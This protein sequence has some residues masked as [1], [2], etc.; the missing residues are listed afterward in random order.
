[1]GLV[2][3]MWFGSENNKRTGF[4]TQVTYFKD[5]TEIE[6]IDAEGNRMEYFIRVDE[7]KRFGSHLNSIGDCNRRNIYKTNETRL[8]NFW[9]N[10]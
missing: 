6:T 2:G 3:T 9:R 8:A 1:M 10:R 4:Q 7:G 5:G